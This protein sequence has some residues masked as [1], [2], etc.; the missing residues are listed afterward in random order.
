MLFELFS[1]TLPHLLNFYLLLEALGWAQ[2]P[3]L[4]PASLQPVRVVLFPDSI[5]G[6]L[7]TLHVLCGN[8]TENFPS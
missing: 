8:H 6:N 4:P 7:Q 3:G 2:S 5:F 1:P